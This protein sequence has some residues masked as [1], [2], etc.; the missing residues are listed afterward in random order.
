[1]SGAGQAENG[2]VSCVTD[3]TVGV[4]ISPDGKSVTFNRGETIDPT[5][6]RWTEFRVILCCQPAATG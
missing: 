4:V 5:Q 1:V 6:N 3:T 2:I